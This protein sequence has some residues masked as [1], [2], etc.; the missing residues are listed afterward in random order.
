MSRIGITSDLHLGLTDVATVWDLR[1]RLAA[2]ACDLTVLAGDLGEPLDRFAACLDIFRE[3]PG[4]VMA[5]AGNHDLWARGRWNSQDLWTHSIAEAVQARGMGYL[6]TSVWRAGDLAVMGTVAWYDYS[7]ADPRGPAYTEEDFVIAKR[8]LN[9]DAR[10]LIWAWSDPAFARQVGEDCMAHLAAL[11]ADASV[12]DILLI[13]HVPRNRCE[14]HGTGSCGASTGTQEA[15]EVRDQ[16]AR[17]YGGRGA[18][19]HRDHHGGH[20]GTPHWSGCT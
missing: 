11:E 8:R 3:M 2:E 13:T 18:D 20:P 1:H 19:R 6:E 9:N 17:R 4:T 7:A 12:H 10:Y 15:H 16:D 5:L 14:R